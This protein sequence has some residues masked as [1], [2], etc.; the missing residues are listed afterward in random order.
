MS[1]EEEYQRYICT[2][3]FRN[4]GYQTCK[5]RHFSGTHAIKLT[6]NNIILLC[7][8]TQTHPTHTHV[9]LQDSRLVETLLSLT[10]SESLEG[11]SLTLVYRRDGIVNLDLINLVCEWPDTAECFKRAI[12][13]LTYNMLHA[14]AAPVVFYRKK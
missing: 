6:G 14:H 5:Q 3:M 9:S 12:N 13:T 2:Y 4:H 1:V 11:F 7:V 10:G 8:C